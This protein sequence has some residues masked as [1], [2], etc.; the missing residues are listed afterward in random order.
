MK[1]IALVACV[2]AVAASATAETLIATGPFE[3]QAG[4]IIMIR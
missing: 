2:A 4:V 1:K 3:P